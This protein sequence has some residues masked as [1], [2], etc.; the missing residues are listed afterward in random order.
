MRRP[1]STY[2]LAASLALLLTGATHAAAPRLIM[3]SG[4]P[5]GDPI[6]V[7]EAGEAFDLYGSF[8]EGRP[9]DRSR[10]EGRPAL[11]LGFF[12]D[13]ALWEPY[14][15]A[16]RLDELKPQQANQVGWFY[17]AIRGEP[18]LIEIPAAGKW[19]KMA[20]AATV[21]MFEARGVPVRLDEDEG[22]SVPW[23]AVGLVAGGVLAISLLGLA[24]RFRKARSPSLAAR[25]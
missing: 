6:L 2:A 18:A 4:E 7:S 9:V 23:I 20:S 14:V 21:R 17:P 13:N 22:G 1:V 5:L 15:R 3:I 12:W 24:Q 10:L 8:H 16:G 11:R 19:P 25:R